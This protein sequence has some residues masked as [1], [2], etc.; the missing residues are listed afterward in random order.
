MP[1]V[2]LPPKDSKTS[3]DRDSL[4]TSLQAVDGISRDK[5]SEMDS[6]RRGGH[7]PSRPR[8][9]ALTSRWACPASSPCLPLRPSAIKNHRWV[10]A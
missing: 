9:I 1:W 5:M 7:T 2:A 4:A 6:G 10:Y 3:P 8:G